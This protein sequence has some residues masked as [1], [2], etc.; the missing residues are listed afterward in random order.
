MPSLKRI[1]PPGNGLPSLPGHCDGVPFPAREPPC[2]ARGLPAFRP[3]RAV[4]AARGRSLDHELRFLA[5]R[6]PHLRPGPLRPWARPALPLW[7]LLFQP[8]AV[9]VG[10][11]CFL[12]FGPRFP[13]PGGWRY[14]RF[15]YPLSRRPLLGLCIPAFPGRGGPP[16]RLRLRLRRPFLG[17][18]LS[19]FPPCLPL[20]PRRFLCDPRQPS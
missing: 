2:P 6:P 10:P 19:R 9:S 15:P 20:R 7:P 12:A 1:P 8:L 13:G 16:L 4:V 14:F 5:G 17:P 11:A 3:E 18:L